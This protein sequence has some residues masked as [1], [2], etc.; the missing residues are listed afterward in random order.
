MHFLLFNLYLHFITSP[1]GVWLFCWLPNDKGVCSHE[2]KRIVVHT[3]HTSWQFDV[4]I[5]RWDFKVEIVQLA[6]LLAAAANTLS[7]WMTAAL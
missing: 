1:V 5:V 4:L 6:L 2:G 3:I 7:V